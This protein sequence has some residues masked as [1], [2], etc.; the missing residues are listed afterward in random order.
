M[1]LDGEPRPS[2]VHKSSLGET[3]RLLSF[4]SVRKRVELNQKHLVEQN[5]DENLIRLSV[6]L[7]IRSSITVAL[8]I[9]YTE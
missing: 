9:H 1:D 3:Q 5:W 2:Q 6:L 4:A 8:Y 7:F